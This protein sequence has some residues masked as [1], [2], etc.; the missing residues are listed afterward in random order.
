MRLGGSCC[1][2]RMFRKSFDPGEGKVKL[3][4]TNSIF[5]QHP[6]CGCH[7][8][9]AI[10]DAESVQNLAFMQHDFRRGSCDTETDC[11]LLV[12]QAI[13]VFHS[14]FVSN[15]CI[16]KFGVVSWTTTTSS[17][18]DFASYLADHFKKTFSQ[19]C[20]SV[21]L[22]FTVW[23]IHTLWTTSGSLH[24]WLP[25]NYRRS[26]HRPHHRLQYWRPGLV[27]NHHRNFRLM[28]G[29]HAVE[30]R[31]AKQS[32]LSDFLRIKMSIYLHS[33]LTWSSVSKFTVL[34]PYSLM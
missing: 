17:E 7:T 31:R 5:T 18:Q 23:D 24:G 2:F 16:A 9:R 30:A 13:I 8:T 34:Q 6:K 10:D 3:D 25:A 20:K 19:N 28:A 12:L 4:Y 26:H 27:Q 32:Y 21:S 22:I 11:Y 14:G 33:L 29:T 15:A 1:T